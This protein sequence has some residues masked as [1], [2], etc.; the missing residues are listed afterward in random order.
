MKF[1]LRV[2]LTIYLEIAGPVN[3]ITIRALFKTQ[4]PSSPYVFQRQNTE[5]QVRELLL[6][7]LN[8]GHVEPTPGSPR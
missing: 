2:A 5:M 4:Y 1:A 8:S 3:S 6:R 7:Q